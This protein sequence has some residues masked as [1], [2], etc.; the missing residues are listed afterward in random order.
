VKRAA[1]FRVLAGIA[2]SGKT[3]ALLAIYRDALSLALEQ[4]RPGTT[5]WLSPTNRAQAEIRRR[6]LDNSLPG[7]LPSSLS[8]AFRPNILTF[9]GFAE[10]ILKSSPQQVTPLSPA[11]QRVLLRRVVTILA[12]QRQLSHFDKIAKTSGF[13][14][15]VAAFISELKRSETWPEHFIDACQK[16]G[17]RPRDRELGLI[18]E[19]YQQALLTGGVYDGEGRFWSSREALAAGHWGRFGDLSLVVVDGF[20][21]FTEAQY[22]ILELLAGKAECLLVS[23]L[24][25]EPAVRVDLFAKTSA[26][27]K[28]LK[29]AGPVSVETYAQSALP[30]AIDHLARRLFANPRDVSPAYEAQGLEVVAVAG[31]SGEVRYLASRIKRLL[32][33]GTNASDIVVAVRDL[34][35][36]AWLIDEVFS[37]AGIP[38]ACEAGVPLSRLAPFKALVNVLS[39][40]LE[41]WPFRRLMSLLDSGLFRPE[42]QEFAAGQAVR[43]VSA[44]LRRNQ[45]FEDRERILAGLERA[46]RNPSAG[47]ALPDL[48]A[49]D[50]RP[51]ADHAHRL[52]VKLSDAC[53]ELRRP[54]DLEGWSRVMASLVRELGFGRSPVDE[55]LP[56]EGRRFGEMLASI[57]FD[58]ARAE[59]VAGIAP[60]QLTLREFVD[61]LTDLIERQR[62]FP[63]TREEGRVRV[64][65][66]E[67]VRNLDVP[68]L[69]LAGLNE[70]SFPRSRND[71]CLYSEGERQELNRHG[72]SLGDR[73]LRAQE[74]LLMFYGVVTRARKQLVLTYPV[75]S[76][77][78]QPLS[79]SPYL[80]ALR[81]LFDSDALKLQLEEQL[82]P[83]PRH[84]R[85]LSPSDAR[86]RGMFDAREGRPELFRAVC[87]T[88]PSAVNCLAAI[89]MNVRRFH[90]RGFSNFEGLLENP[91]NIELLQAR[92]S[93]SHEF[94]ATQ[95]EAYAQC[96]FRFLVSQVLQ[97]EPLVV[98]GVE[99]DFGRRG[100]L[101]HDVLADLHRVLLEKRETASEGEARLRGEDVGQMFQKLLEEKLRARFAA[102]HVQQAL[103][104]I[105]QRLLAEWGVAYGQQWDEFV[106]GLPRE[107]NTPP[108]PARFETAF[109]TPRTGSEPVSENLPPL[110]FGSGSEAVRVGGRI[111]R[112]DVGQVDGRTVYTVI[113]Y[114]TGRS[115]RE[116]IDSVES[117]RKLQ[118]VLYTL[119][120]A[121]L[122]IAGPEGKPWQMGYW[123]VK[124][125]GFAPDIKQK[126]TKAGEPLPPLD[127]AVWQSLVQ[128]LE[129][130]IPRLAAGIRAGRFPVDNADETCTAGCPY[131]TVCR[132]AQI[133]ALPEELGKTNVTGIPAIPPG[134]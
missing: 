93:E 16:R 94:S 22:K 75:V 58:A 52:L 53:G 38:Y 1:G 97:K 9:D 32:L 48:S 111:D 47:P 77:D 82:D 36:Y 69:F 91:R 50:P 131:N 59:R 103:E 30:G 117:G 123:H 21:D 56:A 65:S 130:V 8:A 26:V 132:V 133:R 31:T 127:E 37:L 128:T 106:T 60:V 54:H 71:D 42:W 98:P 66:A 45:L 63:R 80:S 67:Q 20:T 107:G 23:L 129:Q 81:D 68:Y 86:V 62:L 102:S 96:P 2:G 124:E 125:T 122:E 33:D 44:E 72:L 27:I 51:A 101:V 95:L 78:G 29:N 24:Q 64:L 55:G 108:L 109:G 4:S 116:K 7:S 105:E 49:E 5:L 92:F 120:V 18:Y 13:L 14:D 35:D 15:L 99:T 118:L 70:T 28:R 3:T 41:D 126:G 87:E 40:E 73:T 76:D 85:V 79:P 10:E 12:E 110:V 115:S 121:R 46:A 6:L 104:R 113:D 100:T 34:D 114:K 17:T 119:A 74:E 39:L 88:Q 57:Q 19:R 90:T 43:D 11:M 83:V 89:E 84:E 112:I 134:A 25:E 61:E